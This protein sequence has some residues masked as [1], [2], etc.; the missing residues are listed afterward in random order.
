MEVYDCKKEGGTLGHICALF[1]PF[2]CIHKS[3]GFSSLD[4]GSTGPALTLIGVILFRM[5]TGITL[6]PAASSKG[7]WEW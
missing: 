7:L 4:A 6:R 2:E 1:V 3:R 5:G